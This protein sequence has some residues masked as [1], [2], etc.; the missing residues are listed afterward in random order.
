VQV[1]ATFAELVRLGALVPV[2]A[3]SAGGR[4]TREL[5]EDPIHALARFAPLRLQL[6]PHLRARLVSAGR[7]VVVY[8]S[9]VAHATAMAEGAARAG[10]R[11]A[12]V[13]GKTPA[14]QLVEHLERF[15]LPH[16]DPS[17]LDVLT[18]CDLLTQGWD[19]PPVDMLILARGVSAWGPFMQMI[20]RALRPY[21]G[22]A[23]ALVVDLRGSVY[24]HGRPDEDRTF[25]LTVSESQ[26]EKLAALPSL[27]TCLGCGSVYRTAPACP[28]CGRVTPPRRLPSVKRKSLE[29]VNRVSTF[30]ERYRIFQ[31]FCDIA[32]R[33]GHKPGWVGCRYQEAVG[34]WPEWPIPGMQRARRAS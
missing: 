20:G 15:E 30:E 1:R 11:A 16:A 34:R 13:S 17:A 3:I 23:G 8:G 14:A 28:D 22:K 21:P 6:A 33:E 12:V 4:P 19:C 5:T 7:K 9:T 24:L 32:K 27:S 2:R 26:R 10:Y 29:D 25:S 31:R 18:N